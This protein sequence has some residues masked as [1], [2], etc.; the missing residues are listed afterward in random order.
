MVSGGKTNATAP[1]EWDETTEAPGGGG[2]SPSKMAAGRS[3]QDDTEVMPL[4]VWRPAVTPRTMEWGARGALSDR[5]GED[6]QARNFLEML[7]VSREEGGGAGE[8]VGGDPE[9]GVID[10]VAFFGQ[11]HP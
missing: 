7:G 3:E 2:E 11:G 4:G 1:G 9:V 5:I 10:G 6:F 8:G